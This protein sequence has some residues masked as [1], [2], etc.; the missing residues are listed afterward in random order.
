MTDELVA[1]ARELS[2]AGR[3]DR[4]L[5]L[6]DSARTTDRAALDL[7]AAEVALEASWFT[8]SD[9]VGKRL[10]VCAGQSGWEVEFLRLKY[11]YSR[12]LHVGDELRPGPWGKDP[13]AIDDLGRR[14]VALRDRAAGDTRRGW[15]EMLIGWITDN[16][17]AERDAA[18]AHYEAA[19][20]AAGDDDLLGREAL[21][22]LGDH[23]H[24][25]GDYASAWRRWERATELGARA[26]AVPGTLSQ[27]FLLAALHRAEGD[28]AG[29]TALATEVARWSAA[30]GA[31][32]LHGRVA[33]FLTGDDPLAEPEHD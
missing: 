5:A 26:G 13:A 30:I 23:D 31:T 24:D 17:R 6:L 29:A 22:H 18:P 3:W 1:A 28:E 32:R 4:A 14:A 12:L 16:L 7:A 10:A 21:R 25:H 2:N 33:A 19:L 11:E 9:E 15:S 20:A 27:Q 8:G